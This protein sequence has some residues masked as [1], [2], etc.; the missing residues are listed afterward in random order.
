MATYGILGTQT[1]PAATTLTTLVTGST[2]GSVISSFEAC[3]T[4]GSSDSI[5]VALTPSGGT[6]AAANY[7]RYDFVV[8]ANSTL[9][10]QAGWTLGNGETLKVYSTNGNVAF[11]ATGSVL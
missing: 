8:P 11:T 5:R 10:I 2:N 4:T 3:N 6:T 1:K 7:V 9:S